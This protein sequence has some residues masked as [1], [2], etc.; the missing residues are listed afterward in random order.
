MDD[1]D[2]SFEHYYSDDE[3]SDLEQ[4]NTEIEPTMSLKPPKNLNVNSELDMA[5]NGWSG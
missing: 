5:R 2:N 4:T 3:T 1:S